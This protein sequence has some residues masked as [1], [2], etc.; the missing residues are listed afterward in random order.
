M[1]RRQNSDPFGFAAAIDWKVVEENAA[2][3]NAI[4]D[5]DGAQ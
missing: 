3:I 4:F 5:K 1:A 2:A